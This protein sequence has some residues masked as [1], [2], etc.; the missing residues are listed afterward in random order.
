MSNLNYPRN[1]KMP[2]KCDLLFI[3]NITPLHDHNIISNFFDNI[4]NIDNV[5][6]VPGDRDILFD[7]TFKERLHHHVYS[8]KLL[9]NNITKIYKNYNNNQYNL[10]ILRDESIT[11]NYNNKPIKIYGQSY[12]NTNLFYKSHIHRA[13]SGIANMN[14]KVDVKEMRTHITPCDILYTAYP[15]YGILDDK[16]GCRYL[17]NQVIKIKPKFHIFNGFRGPNRF[18]YKN[19]TFVNSNINHNNKKYIEMEYEDI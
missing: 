13:V 10:Y 18:I 12:I 17:F 4:Y 15:P 6:F 7:D 14:N 9:R 19:I 5:V 8:R 1:V 2:T 3:S 11:I 16:L